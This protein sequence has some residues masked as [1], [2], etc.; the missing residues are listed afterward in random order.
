[1]PVRVIVPPEPLIDVADAKAF[2]RVDHAD[3]DDLIEELIV[4]AQSEVD[5]PHGQ[6]GRAIGLQTLEATFSG[7]AHW[8]PLP[9]PDLNEVVSV[10]YT[11]PAGSSETASGALYEIAGEGIRLKD[12]AAWPAAAYGCDAVRV[13]YKASTELDTAAVERVKLAIKLHVRGHYD[14]EGDA[15]RGAFDSL[16]SSL[17]KFG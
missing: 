13:Q 2:L 11:S 7:F 10:S 4:A 3:D 6:L 5:G 12:G 8:M 1:M 16:L 14:R 9:Y 17:R 15:W